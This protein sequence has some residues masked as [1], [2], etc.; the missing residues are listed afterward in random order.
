MATV[1]AWLAARSGIAFLC[2]DRS[3]AYAEAGRTGAPDAV[4]VADRWHIWKNL[5][6]AVEKTVTRHRACLRRP[7][8]E[9]PAPAAGTLLPDEDEAEQGPR[10]SGRL[11]DRV[12]R[13]HTAVHELISRN[14]SLRGIARQLQLSRGTVRRLARAATPDELLVGRWTNLPSILDD[15]KPY[16]HQRWAEGCTN[17]TRLFHEL[18]E[19]GYE[20]GT[21]VVRRYVSRLREAFPPAGPPRRDPTVRDVTNCLTRHPDSLD[22]DESTQVKDLLDRCPALALTAEHVRAFAELMNNRQGRLL[23]RWIADVRSDDLPDLHTFIN[24]LG[25]DLDAVTAGLTLPY[26]SGVVEGHN[27]KIKMLKRQMFGRANFDLLRK[28]LLLEAAAGRS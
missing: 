1:S 9:V 7:Q 23:H 19:R 27:N 13:Q 16:L 18:K 11:S 28:R 21:T 25:Q 22:E 14:V 5:A 26:S 15:H 20:G 6:E 8:D 10:R 17:A 24:G 2:R 3:S 12:R 4:H